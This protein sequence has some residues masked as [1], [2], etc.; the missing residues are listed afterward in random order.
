[1]NLQQFID[2]SQAPDAENF[3]RQLI[4]F[5]SERDFGLVSTSLIVEAAGRLAPPEIFFVSNTPQAFLESALSVEDSRRDPVMKRMKQLSVPFVYDQALYVSEGAADLWE[6]QAQYGYRNGI[7]VALHLPNSR[8]FLLG[9][10]RERPLPRSEMQRVRLMADLQLLAVHAQE[11][12][13]RLFTPQSHLV[14]PRMTARELEILR[15]TMEGKS[16]WAVGEIMGVSEHTVN[17]HFRSIFRK[18]DAAS[19]HQ[20]VLKAISLGLI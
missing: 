17:F 20:A 7:A 2:I 11:A 15:W 13:S 16:A 3:K 1:M 9:V 6:T 18:L 8:H 4:E 10:D 5:A 19:K 12:A 14:A